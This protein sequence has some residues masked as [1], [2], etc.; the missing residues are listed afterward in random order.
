MKPLWLSSGSPRRRQL[1]EWAGFS[2]EVH[3]P[4][5]DETRRPDEPAIDMVQRLAADKCIGPDDRIV[6]SADTIVHLGAD[7]LGKPADDSE[8]RSMLGALS[9]RW[10][11]V[12]TG[13]AIRRQGQSEVFAVTTRVRFR[14]LSDGDIQR[15]VDT[16]EPRDK[17]GAYGIQGIGGALVAEVRGSWTNVMG[18]PVERTLTHLPDP[19]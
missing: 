6:V 3:P 12:T 5:V 8:A 1:L 13:V 15:Y 16:G 2:V 18:L 9:G 14:T 17:A 11:D 7:V 4:D 19:S 10:H